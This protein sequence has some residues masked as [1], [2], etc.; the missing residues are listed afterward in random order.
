MTLLYNTKEFS[1]CK[2]KGRKN[3]KMFVEHIS[4]IMTFERQEEIDVFYKKVRTYKDWIECGAI[5]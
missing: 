3:S 5:L 1:G 2:I 4:A